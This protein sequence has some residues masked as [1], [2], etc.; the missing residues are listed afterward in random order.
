MKRS[1]A[2]PKRNERNSMFAL[3]MTY[4]IYKHIILEY[5][6]FRKKFVNAN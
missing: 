2:R 5:T 6:V 3:I 1:N 4:K